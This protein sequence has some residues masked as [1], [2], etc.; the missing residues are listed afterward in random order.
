M[1]NYYFR[2]ILGYF[3]LTI[4]H[5]ILSMHILV[6][7]NISLCL[8]LRPKFICFEKNNTRNW[9]IR[10]TYS[11]HISLTQVAMK[12]HPCPYTS[13]LRTMSCHTSCCRWGKLIID[14]DMLTLIP[15]AAISETNPKNPCDKVVC[16]QLKWSQTAINQALVLDKEGF[17]I[18]RPYCRG[19]L[20]ENYRIKCVF[21]L[22]YD[23]K[24]NWP[25]KYM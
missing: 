19:R 4:Q 9:I 15:T 22:L 5:W 20:N 25:T 17:F 6:Y 7:L 16:N 1:R 12:Q 8:K 21:Y 23:F 2:H 14:D 13:R 10:S 3:Q 24:M 11:N 18:W